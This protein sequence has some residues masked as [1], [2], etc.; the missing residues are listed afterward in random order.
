M[1]GKS[2]LILEKWNTVLLLGEPGGGKGT[3]AA[4]IK[5]FWLPEVVIGSMG[6]IFRE[7]AKTDPEI[8]NLIN[9]GTL[10]SDETACGLYREFAENVAKNEQISFM[11]G[12]PRTRDQALNIIRFVRKKGWRVLVIYLHCTLDVLTER[13]IAR[14]RA[15]DKLDVVYKRHDD[16][17]RLHPPII[18]EL[19]NRPDLFDI[20]DLDGTQ[21]IDVVFTNFL[22]G[23]IR[24]IDALYMYEIKTI[25]TSLNIWE[26][27]PTISPAI[28]RMICEIL[29]TIQANID[30]DIY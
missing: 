11:D 13:L 30:G 27:E 6:D 16:F 12:F 24:L 17:T 14:R 8:A 1:Q 19:K 25:P 29:K 15:D 7:K 20:I 28:N 10:I 3:L 18:A 22:L 21:P 5:N 4:N 26:N 2:N 23:V 9:S